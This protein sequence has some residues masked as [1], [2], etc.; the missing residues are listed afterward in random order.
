ME[1][2]TLDL[3]HLS[4]HVVEAGEGPLVV[5]LHGFPEGWHTWRHQLP[6]LADAGYRVVAPDQRGYGRTDRPEDAALYTQLHLVGDVVALIGAL[7]GGPAVVV[8]HDW[9]APVAW[10]TALLRP[11]LVRGVVGMSVP[12]TPPNELDI[13]SALDA[14]V[15]PHHYQRWFQTDDARREWERD[16]RTSL[17]RFYNALSGHD[18]VT[19]DLV[20]GEG[21]TLLDALPDDDD[22]PPWTT[23]E[24]FGRLV[25][26]FETAGFRGGLNWYRNAE[27]NRDL[28]RPWTMRPIEVPAG[29]VT[30]ELDVV[31]RWP[32]MSDLVAMLPALLPQHVETLVLPG[33]GHWTGEER[34]DDVNAFLLRFL[35]AL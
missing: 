33:C 4:M 27:R 7:G 17:A 25:G 29:Y 35:A 5:L 15:G 14:S 28:L 34:P 23:E 19:H 24:D 26:D 2:R 31:Y 3:G 22:L 20:L 9:G 12:Y 32:G 6:V 10:N 21:R 13:L 30:G 8:G 11:D 18:G 1:H 16:P